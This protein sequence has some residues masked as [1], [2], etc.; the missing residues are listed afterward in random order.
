MTT[1]LSNMPVFGGVDD[2][3]LTYLLDHCPRKK[4]LEGEYFFHEDDNAKAMY[5][6]QCGQVRVEK[7]WRDRVIAMRTLGKG[8]CFGEM[9]LIDLYPRSA[10]VVALEDCEALEIEPSL[11]ATIYEHDQQ[12]FTII[13]MNM[14]REISRR[15]RETDRHYFESSMMNKT[16]DYKPNIQFV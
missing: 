4:R 14:A 6:L 1:L 8:D 5:V 16:G 2:K 11:L 9:A 10:S 3:L 7:K 12:A 15:L 13:Y